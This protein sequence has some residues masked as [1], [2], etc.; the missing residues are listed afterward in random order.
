M[1]VQDDQIAQLKEQNALLL[2]A[3]VAFLEGNL[4][5]PGSAAGFLK[6]ID[7]TL[8]VTPADFAIGE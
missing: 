6:A 8:Q 5:G 7:P 3:V 1:T 2:R 4:D